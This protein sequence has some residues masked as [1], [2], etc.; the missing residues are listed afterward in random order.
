MAKRSK[1]AS[2]TKTRSRG[3]R[4]AVKKT[5]KTTAARLTLDDGM[6]VKVIGEHTRRKD[7][8]YGKQYEALRKAGTVGAFFKKGGERE[9]LRAAIKDKFVKVA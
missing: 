1:A 4:T 5:A 6:H 7:S 2:K 3:S 8:R 9:V